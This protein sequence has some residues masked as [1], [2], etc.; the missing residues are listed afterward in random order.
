M[1]A[2]AQ[3]VEADP[4][5]IEPEI[6]QGCRRTGDQVRLEVADHFLTVESLDIGLQRVEPDRFGLSRHERGVQELGDPH[7]GDPGRSL[8]QAGHREL[9][10]HQGRGFGRITRQDHRSLVLGEPPF[11]DAGPEPGGV[12]DIAWQRGD[13]SIETRGLHLLSRSFQVQQHATPLCFD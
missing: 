11:G 13:Q 4:R 5:A 6:A 10:Q 9:R 12:I 7:P 3:I 1:L 2:E 8:E